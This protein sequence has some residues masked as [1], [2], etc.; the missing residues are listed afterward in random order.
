[1]NVITILDMRE[2]CELLGISRTT[3]WRLIKESKIA[4][5]PSCSRRIHPP[6]RF[7]EDAVL[8]LRDSGRTRH[9]YR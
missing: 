4:P 1:M 8:K 2:T 3:L 7:D 5:L 9:Y 6:L